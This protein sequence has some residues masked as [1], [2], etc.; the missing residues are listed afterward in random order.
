MSKEILAS[1]KSY[2][3]KTLILNPKRAGL[4]VVDMQNDFLNPKS[5]AYTENAKYIIPNIKKLI[6][7]A[8]KNNIPVMYTAH[9]HQD[10]KIDGGMT[11]EW[12]PE[13]RNKQTLVAGSKGAEIIKE[14][15]PL[16]DEKIVYKHRYSAFY[17]TDLEIYLRGLDIRDLIVTGIM[18]GICVESTVRDAF[19]R[20]FRVFVVADATAAGE[21]ELHLNSLKI[22]AYAFAQITTTKGLLL[23][24]KNFQKT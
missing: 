18:T 22:M 16:P 21:Q 12:W 9:C 3:H 19:F 2:Q 1:I 14:L 11:A 5:L 4:L 20:D 6:E 17:N 24:I 10:P 13:I 8:R 7:T 23:R 15:S